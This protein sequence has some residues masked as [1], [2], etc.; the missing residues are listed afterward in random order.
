M[1]QTNDVL[2]VALVG[3]PNCGKSTLFN[4]L[5]GLNQKTGNFPGVTV[6]KH[7]GKVRLNS[8]PGKPSRT[9]NFIDLPGTYSLF[10]KSPDEEETLLALLDRSQA[11]APDLV[12]LVVDASNL[13][14]S[15]LLATQV[16]DT[17]I[18]V[19]LALNM[20]DLL[21]D[22]GLSANHEAL[23]EWLGVPVLPLSAR[24]KTGL[25]K[26]RQYLAAAQ[27]KAYTETAYVDNL[28]ATTLPKL[29]KPAPAALLEKSRSGKEID[30]R[31]D[32]LERYT[33]IEAGLNKVLVETK[34][35]KALAVTH[36]IDRF[37][38]HPVMG[39]LAFLGVMLLIFQAIFSWSEA[40]MNLIDGAFSK[41]SDWLEQ[42][43]PPGA[44]SD[45]ITQ[46]IVPG[47][48]GIVIFIPQIAILF[49]FIAIL[50]DS[51]YM[52]RVSFLLDKLLRPFGLNG[53]S[54]IPL[55][56]SV[57]CAVPSIMSARTIKHSRERLLT[58]FI[59]PLI[60]CSARLPVYTLLIA[61][62]VPESE[63]GTFNTRGL[64]LM[65]LYL[66]GFLAA[67]L[68]AL[69]MKFWMKTRERSMFIMEMPI[70]RLPQW[71]VVLFTMYDKA[72]VFVFD[73]GKI[74]VAISIVL[75][76]LASYSLPGRFDKLEQH[77]SSAAV[78]EQLGEEEAATQLE[79]E[80]LR[81][82]F[83]G[84]LGRAIEPAIAPLG[85]D[86][87]IGIALVTSFAAR[88]VF[89][90]TM[91]TIYSAGDADETSVA[92]REKMQRDT[93]HLTGRKLFDFPTSLGLMLFYAFAMQCMSTMAVVKRETGSWKWPLLQFVW[94]GALA[95]I[96]AFF[97][98]SAF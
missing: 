73:A 82:S 71:R 12:L 65:A 42:T 28:L 23:Q 96:A 17:G 41:A 75:W 87:K 20:V 63:G 24:G 84:M 72:K 29:T 81:N 36:I 95:W 48:G 4:A 37:L 30:I 98:Q 94:F 90:G 78:V 31:Q 1:A 38:T 54:V 6:E 92:L 46:G 45:L 59:T 27:P 61:I 11:D 67:L 21:E 47:L 19:A 74:I 22:S 39:L 18:P 66:L 58:I 51:G 9:V 10:P 44:F 13:K 16:I 89:V 26:L 49:G 34:P 97:A 25:S 83:A 77:Y 2:H 50:E 5:T 56:S 64:I 53:K 8:G 80:K 55:I 86:W 68:T 91:A 60:S 32:T 93:H 7:S 88:E 70:Y 43:L 3:N 40:P 76:V 57:A 15:L 52:A 35:L 62:A 85:F 14:R 79:S 69:L 33:R